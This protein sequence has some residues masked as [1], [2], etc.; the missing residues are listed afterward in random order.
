M[1][2][3]NLLF[4][5]ILEPYFIDNIITIILSY[6]GLD[7]Q[8]NTININVDFYIYGLYLINEKLY[9]DS[10]KIAYFD[11]YAKKFVD[12]KIRTDSGG[13]HHV[14]GNHIIVCKSSSVNI[15]N[16]NYELEKNIETN[17]ISCRDIEFYEDCMYFLYYKKI[18]RLNL[19][20]KEIYNVLTITDNPLNNYFCIYNHELYLFAGARNEFV[21]YD[22]NTFHRKSKYQ[23]PKDLNKYIYSYVDKR[24]FVTEDYIFLYI[25][26][27]ILIFYK[28]F[29]L[30]RI[31]DTNSY[32]CE[33]AHAFFVKNNTIFLAQS[34]NFKIFE[35]F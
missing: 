28:D 11:I 1:N 25:V 23:L 29:S 13:V 4:F 34:S 5:N 12:S 30:F 32:K 19:K 27:C 15:Y 7:F 33:F 10:K 17:F 14:R 3:N 18:M 6:K 20:N 21:V 16:L 22:I 24:V 31:I 8:I 9:F 26:S 35:L 2:N